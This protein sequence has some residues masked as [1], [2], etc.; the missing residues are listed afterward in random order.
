M[1]TNHI[2]PL[3]LAIVF[4][5]IVLVG[6][7]QPSIGFG[8]N[9]KI[10]GL[11]SSQFMGS[12]SSC[13]IW[14][15]NCGSS[16]VTIDGYLRTSV[17]TSATG[18]H[19]LQNDTIQALN[20]NAGDSVLFPFSIYYKYGQCRIGNNILVIWPSL[21]TGNGYIASCDTIASDSLTVLSFPGLSIDETHDF[22]EGIFPNPVK[23]K[24]T[25]K[26]VSGAVQPEYISIIDLSGREWMMGSFTETI[27][28]EGLEKGIYFIRLLYA[29]KRSFTTRFVKIE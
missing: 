27:N 17:D 6:K 20:I 23:D 11:P 22:I 7:A 4:L 8:A 9:G 24:L 12:T 1:R 18:I 29:D 19:F 10:F 26:L 28:L 16:N 15:K 14:L 13:N 3:V 2:K 5:A 21:T 25:L